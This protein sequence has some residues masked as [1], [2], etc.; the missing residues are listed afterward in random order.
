MSVLQDIMC[1]IN[2]LNLIDY[3]QFLAYDVQLI[4]GGKKYELSPEEYIF[5]SLTLYLDII[6]IFML[7][8]ALFGKR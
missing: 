8:L 1:V 4:M 5:A 6:R 7:L 2:K 3:F